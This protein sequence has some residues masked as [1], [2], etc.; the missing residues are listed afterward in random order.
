MRF[1]I[2]SEI[3]GRTRLQ[4]AGPVPE[5]ISMHFFKLSGD[6]DGVHKVRVYGRI[7]QMALEYDEPRRASVLDAPRRT[8]CSSYRRCQVGL[9]DATRAAQAQTRYGP[10]DTYRRPLRAPLVL[11]DASACGVCRGRLHG[12]LRAA[13]REL[14]QPRLTVPC[15]TLRPSAFRSSSVMST[16]RARRCSCSTWASCSRTTPAP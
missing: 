7:G 4:L 9:R 6:I 14:A 16:P 13:L 2:I 12:I 15:S 1:S 11:A 3:P 5:A 10:G 8:R